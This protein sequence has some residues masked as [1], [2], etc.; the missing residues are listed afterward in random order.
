M[1]INTAPDGPMLNPFP[2]NH[3]TIHADA[4]TVINRL[5]YADLWG[6]PGTK[7]N[8]P[9]AR[10][11][12]QGYTAAGQMNLQ[13]QVNNVPRPSTLA[14]VLVDPT[15][16]AVLPPSPRSV[17][18]QKEIVRRIKGA[19]FNSLNAFETGFPTIW[20]VTGTPSS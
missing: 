5:V 4:V 12:L 16:I 19:L 7:Q 10:L 17:P 6:A 11:D 14:T 1:A 3:P 18:Q 13:V 20:T 15:V 2:G 8:Q 9:N